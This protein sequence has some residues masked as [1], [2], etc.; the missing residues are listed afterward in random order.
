MADVIFPRLDTSDSRPVVCLRPREHDWAPSWDLPRSTEMPSRLIKGESA[1]HC[2]QW[3]TS[4]HSPA[5]YISPARD[6][7]R[8]ELLLHGLIW[9]GGTCKRASAARCVVSVYFPFPAFIKLHSSRST[10][11]FPIWT[12]QDLTVPMTDFPFIPSGNHPKEC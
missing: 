10:W 2:W 6:L 5:A 9:G 3:L 11:A 8:A 4:L 7:T 12:I 1:W